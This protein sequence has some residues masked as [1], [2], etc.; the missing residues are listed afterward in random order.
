MPIINGL[1]LR[2]Y[3]PSDITRCVEIATAYL[4]EDDKIVP[5]GTVFTPEMIDRSDE[6]NWYCYVWERNGNVAGFASF[7]IVPHKNYCE[8]LYILL[9]TR[10]P[11]AERWKPLYTF[12]KGM[13]IKAK[14]EGATRIGGLV[15]RNSDVAKVLFR[16]WLDPVVDKVE[17]K[18]ERYV[19]GSQDMFWI[20]EN[21]DKVITDTDMGWA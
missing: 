3:E 11:K 10:V 9:D 19:L 12:I 8:I 13:A 6:P 14:R 1:D 4:T 17:G 18:Q 7:A 15:P 2:P 21:V 20:H 16:F 5:P